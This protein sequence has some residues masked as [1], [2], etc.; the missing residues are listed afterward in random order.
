MQDLGFSMQA[1]QTAETVLAS[2][3]GA[4]QVRHI[5]GPVLWLPQATAKTD[6]QD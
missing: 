2:R 3:R 5:Q 1:E 4:G 6:D